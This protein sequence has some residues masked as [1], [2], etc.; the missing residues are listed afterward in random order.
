MLA[1]KIAREV[2]KTDKEEHGPANTEEMESFIMILTYIMNRLI[3][4]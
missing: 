3:T 4:R 1:Y 2:L